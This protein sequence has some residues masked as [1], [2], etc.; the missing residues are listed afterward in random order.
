M[1]NG[2]A[3][4][5]GMD[6]RLRRK[7]FDESMKNIDFRFLENG[8]RELRE[9][10]DALMSEQERVSDENERIYRENH[11]TMQDARTAT[12][13]IIELNNT[14]NKSESIDI[15]HHLRVARHNEKQKA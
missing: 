13:S 11:P 10:A 14:G 6:P 1:E 2:I 7:Q 12:I 4:F 8:E 9:T 5:R 3:T 15:K